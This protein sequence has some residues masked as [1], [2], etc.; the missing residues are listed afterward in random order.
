MHLSQEVGESGNYIAGK[1]DRMPPPR[2]LLYKR[3]PYLMG[4]ITYN[5]LTG[6]VAVKTVVVDRS[7]APLCVPVKVTLAG[8]G[9]GTCPG[10]YKC[11]YNGLHQ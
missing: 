8:A 2:I 5:G 6:I 10:I 7:L 3:S 11:T 1:N 4:I 9:T